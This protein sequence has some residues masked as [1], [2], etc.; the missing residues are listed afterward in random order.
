M[1]FSVFYNFILIDATNRSKISSDRIRLILG[2]SL[3]PLLFFPNTPFKEQEKR[4]GIRDISCVE[5]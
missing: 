2:F 1:A 3:T 5:F 4:E